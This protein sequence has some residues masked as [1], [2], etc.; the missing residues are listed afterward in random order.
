MR[1][2]CDV[3]RPTAAG[4]GERPPAGL[5]TRDNAPMSVDEGVRLELTVLGC[6]TAAPHPASGA[7]G[8][9][10]RW[11]ETSL[12]LDAGQGVIR[13][14]QR[15]IHP[16]RLSAAIIGHMHADH[17]L[18]VAALRYLYAWGEEEIDRLPL[19]LPPGG[20]DRI[21]ALARAISERVGFFEASFDIREYDPDRPLRIG[22][23][24]VTFVR[25]RHYVPAWGVVVEAPD[26]SRLA[27]TGDT[28]PSERV[29]DAVA[30]ADLLLVEAALESSTSDDEER[31]HLTA[32]EAIDLAT[33][34][35]VAEALLVHYA[36]GRLVELERTCG[37]AGP[38]VRPAVPGMSVR[39]GEGHD[40]ARG[41]ATSERPTFDDL[42]VARAL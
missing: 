36:P 41:R 5:A 42:S 4:S 35:G 30:G 29:A 28:G 15:V 13:E 18:D 20:E 26:G 33:R 16:R 11:G 14:L 37:L 24:T 22:D 19:H 31:G 10:V 23:L 12:L 2:P 25:G 38:W 32:E 9:L 8:Y 40:R 21:A 39:V 34:S 7:A 3:R 6:S 27:Y 1:C 17:Y